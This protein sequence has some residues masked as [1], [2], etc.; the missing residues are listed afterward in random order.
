M[1]LKMTIAESI[2]WK[3]KPSLDLFIAEEEYFR[4]GDLFLGNFVDIRKDIMDCLNTTLIKQFLSADLVE[5]K[6]LGDYYKRRL[7]SGPLNTEIKEMFKASPHDLKFE[8]VF[9]ENVFYDS[10]SIGGFDFAS[11]DNEYNV[12]N[13]WNFCYGRRAVFNGDILWED[14]LNKSYRSDWKSLAS[15]L[16]L[17]PLTT[18]KGVDLI[19]KKCKPTIIGEVQ[20]GNW[21]LVYRDILKAIQIEQAEDIDLLIYITA[22]GNLSDYISDGTVKFSETKR[23]FEESKNVLNVP[24]W[25]I[26]IDVH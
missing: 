16:G 9:E 24:I 12:T 13:F 15:T 7:Q 19:Q 2:I 21:A 23:I 5:S 17:N 3:T 18:L 6:R 22:T 11:Y 25:L 20:F 8:V 4:H 10:P 14:E 26:G 1:K